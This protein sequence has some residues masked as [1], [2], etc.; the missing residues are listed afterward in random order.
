MPLF[1]VDITE[2]MIPYVTNRTKKRSGSCVNPSPHRITSGGIPIG[3]EPIYRNQ[4]F[5]EYS[6]SSK[7]Y[8]T[9]GGEEPLFREVARVLLEYGFVHPRTPTIPKY[10]AGFVI[11]AYEGLKVDWVTVITDCLKS[12]IVSL[13]EGKKSWTGVAQWL[14]LLVPPVL[15]IK[16]KK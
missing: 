1:E 10:Q 8:Q 13:V 12:A 2:A 11:T 3:G 14:T 5:G 4:Y 9:Q 6:L 7:A 15:T 16:P